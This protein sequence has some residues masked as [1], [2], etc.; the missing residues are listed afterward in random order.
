MS[1][2]AGLS[3]AVEVISDADAA[4]TIAAV[5][6]YIRQHGAT[7]SQ[8]AE[9]A[10]VDPATFTLFM[11]RKMP[12]DWQGITRKAAE[13][14]A[15]LQRRLHRESLM[16]VMTP[17]VTEALGMVRL[18]MADGGIGLIQGD[19]GTGKTEEVNAVALRNE[20]AI[21]VQAST[22]RARPKPM[23]EDIG[24]R[25]GISYYAKDTAD[26]YRAVRE[27][28][29]LYSLLVVDEAHKYIAEA[30]CLHVLADLVKETGVP[31]LWTAT[32]DLRRYLDRRIGQWHDPF[33]QIRSRISHTIDLA[34]AGADVIRPEDIRELARRKFDLKLDAVAARNLCDLARLEN[35][36][37]MRLV[38]ST[39]NGLRRPARSVRSMPGWSRWQWIEASPVSARVNASAALRQCDRLRRLLRRR[40]H[41]SKKGACVRRRDWPTVEQLGEAFDYNPNHLR[42][43]A[44]ATFAAAGQAYRGRSDR[45]QTC[46]RINS[47]AVARHKAKHTKPARL[48]ARRPRAPRRA[49]SSADGAQISIT[50]HVPERLLRRLLGSDSNGR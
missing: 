12:A 39:S 46:W 43:I 16:P 8:L 24:Q 14:L 28:M 1:R 17:T 20:K 7:H 4:E 25:M 41:Q 33:V 47:A 21:I 13:A 30:K 10:G 38:E 35:E 44:A 22:A 45:G 5:D 11:L 49:D 6:A 27:R 31:Q 37:A 36:G 29:Q 23:L 50:I 48:A 19:S 15:G 3:A 34:D 2:H 40:R 9:L 18:L 32:G 26:S 42:R